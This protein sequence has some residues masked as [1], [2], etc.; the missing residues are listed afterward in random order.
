MS[1]S[2]TMLKRIILAKMNYFRGRQVTRAIF[3]GGSK[4]ERGMVDKAS[5]SDPDGNDAEEANV[6]ILLRLPSERVDSGDSDGG[7]DAITALRR[8]LST[9]AGYFPLL[10][11]LH[12]TLGSDQLG[13]PA[14]EVDIIP[15]AIVSQFI[16]IDDL[17]SFV[18]NTNQYAEHYA[19]V[20]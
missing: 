9:G 16:T 12:R 7:V 10:T 4:K 5:V 14:S 2:K 3:H 19:K 13:S 15:T 11:A 18:T 6:V 17:A 1:A 8:D 20:G